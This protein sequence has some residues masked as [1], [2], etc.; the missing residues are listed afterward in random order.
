M[1][2]VYEN[3]KDRFYGKIK[4]TKTCW[5]WTA[6]V[7]SFG[8]GQISVN[9]KSVGAHRISWEIH[10]GS[11]LD[12]LHVLHKCDNPPCVNPDH[13]FLGTN[14]DN[15]EDRYV[16]GRC[17]SSHKFKTHCKHGHEFSPENTVKHKFKTKT[18]FGFGRKC[19]T[20]RRAIDK[21][22]KKS[23]KK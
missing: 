8:Y 3:L 17:F 15:V 2:F 9:G 5:Y 12:G 18:G 13:L 21:K 4:K 11:I 7:S 16:K 22:Y 23:K 6:C 14:K 19:L 10:N 1:A 20:C